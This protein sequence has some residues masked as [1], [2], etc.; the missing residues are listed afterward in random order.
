MAVKQLKKLERI[1]KTLK[2]TGVWDR[3][4]H[5]LIRKHGRLRALQEE[6]RKGKFIS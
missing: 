3:Y 5:G 4:L 2:K 6:L 1:Y